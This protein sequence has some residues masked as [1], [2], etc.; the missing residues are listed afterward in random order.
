M[1]EILQQRTE[2]LKAEQQH[3]DEEV[4]ADKEEKPAAEEVDADTEGKPA[5]EEVAADTEEK[6]VTE[7][8]SM[9]SQAIIFGCCAVCPVLH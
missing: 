6:P 7:H 4:A 5:T 8:V 9:S 3:V 2:I 1:H